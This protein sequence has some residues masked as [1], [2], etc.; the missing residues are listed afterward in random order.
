VVQRCETIGI[1]IN[2]DFSPIRTHLE[3]G[4]QNEQYSGVDANPGT[5]ASTAPVLR[6]AKSEM[7]NRIA[8]PEK[9]EISTRRPIPSGSW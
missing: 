7:T 6:A 4:V 5:T 1:R 9:T 8:Q 2:H 3:A